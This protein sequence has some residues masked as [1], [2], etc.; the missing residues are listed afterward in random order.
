MTERVLFSRVIL[1]RSEESRILFPRLS[2]N[3]LARSSGEG[4]G[5][6]RCECPMRRTLRLASGTKGRT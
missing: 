3:S 6:L 2:L 1:E 4:E 5:H